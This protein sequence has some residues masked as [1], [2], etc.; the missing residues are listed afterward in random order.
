MNFLADPYE[1]AAPI[2]LPGCVRAVVRGRKWRKLW[3]SSFS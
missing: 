3:M 1:R 2:N